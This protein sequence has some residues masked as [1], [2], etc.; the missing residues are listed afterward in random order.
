MEKM[1]SGYIQSS[2][3]AKKRI[4]ELTA[5]RSNLRKRGEISK[6]NDLHL[7]Q[8]IKLLYDENCQMQ[9]I[10]TILNCYIRRSGNSV[11]T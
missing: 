2:E 7:D 9:E 5:L 10:I 3:L 8:R 11:K 1:L 6:I 4:V